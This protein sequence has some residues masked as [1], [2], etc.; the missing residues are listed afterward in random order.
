MQLEGLRIYRPDEGGGF[1]REIPG[2]GP[3]SSR[4]GSPVASLPR[5]HGEIEGRRPF[6]VTR[7]P[8]GGLCAIVEVWRPG[9]FSGVVTPA[10]VQFLPDGGAVSMRFE[11]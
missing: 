4:G 11:A 9:E 2:S 10:P 1:H 5:F 6:G 3:G 8:I 7:W